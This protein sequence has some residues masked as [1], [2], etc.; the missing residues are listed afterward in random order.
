M[1]I[2]DG[3]FVSPTK[4]FLSP[5]DAVGEIS[6]FINEDPG[7]FYRV[8]IGSDSQ[9][10]RVNG[11]DEISFVTA[12]IIHREGHGARYFWRKEKVNKRPILRDKIY[13]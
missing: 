5:E 7:R 8:V 9:T 6:N 10:H 4:G 13:I 12:L 2:K 3:L 11:Q 1:A